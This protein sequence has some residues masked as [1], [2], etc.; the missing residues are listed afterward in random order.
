MSVMCV[1]P[2]IALGHDT[3]G[4][5]APLYFPQAFCY[6]VLHTRECQDLFIKIY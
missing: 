1:C 5:T 2:L 6:Y 4:T 3:L